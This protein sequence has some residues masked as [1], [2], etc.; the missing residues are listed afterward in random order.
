MLPDPWQAVHRA[1]LSAD[2]LIR[3]LTR[4]GDRE[5]IVADG[6]SWSARAVAD[7]ISRYA[8]AYADWG[9]GVGSPVATLSGNRAEVLIQIGANMVTGARSTPLHPLGSLDDQ[10]FALADAGIETLFYDPVGFEERAFALRERVPAVRLIAL[11]K[12]ANSQDLATAAAKFGPRSLRAPDVRPEDIYQVVYTGGTTG[13]PKGVVGTWANQIALSTILLNEW[14]WPQGVRLLCATPLSH[15]GRTAFLPAM[16]R[17][18]AIIVQKGFD[19]EEF[20][21]AI[22]RHAISS[23]I[24]V[25]TMIYRLLEQPSAQADLATLQ[26]IYYGGSAISPARLHEAIGRF[27]SIFFQ[28]YGQAEC[29]MAV[30]V[31]RPQE[32]LLERPERLASCGRPLPWLDVA[33]LDD[34]GVPVRHGEPGEICVRGA[35]VMKE[36]LNQPEQTAEALRFGWLHTGDVARRDPEGFFTIV[37]RKKDVIISGGFNVYP[38]EIE[39]VLSAHAGVSAAAVIGVPH[40][41]WGEAVKAIVVRRPSSTVSEQEL[42]ALVR[43]RKGAIAAPKSVEFV[44]AIPLSPLGKPDRKALRARYWPAAGRQVN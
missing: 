8:Q 11:A 40:D 15:A 37:D 6:E 43:E 41:K 4:N 44:E 10:A 28:F 12:T 21:D 38:R 22:G 13:R 27:G 25:P 31:M 36:Y 5:A 20:L 24:L 17:G 35:L 34:E 3:S 42:V 26:R 16:V 18:G 30:C 39:D 14:D 29:P 19:P 1:A 32:H 9:I 23:S 7:E 33:L 2:V